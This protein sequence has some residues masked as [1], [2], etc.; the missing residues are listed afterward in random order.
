V[1]ESLR[2]VARV[3]I[4]SDQ[5]AASGSVRSGNLTG[6]QAEAYSLSGEYLSLNRDKTEQIEGLR[7]RSRKCAVT[8]GFAPS[9]SWDSAAGRAEQI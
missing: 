2:A 8:F 9:N 6:W 5:Y 3:E 4:V 1:A 7:V